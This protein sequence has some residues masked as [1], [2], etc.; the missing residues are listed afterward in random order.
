MAVEPIDSITRVT[1]MRRMYG[2]LEHAPTPEERVEQVQE[3]QRG[4]RPLVARQPA[5]VVPP[6]DRDL[7][8]TILDVERLRT[9]DDQPPGPSKAEVEA[10]YRAS[11]LGSQFWRVAELPAV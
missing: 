4:T 10:A 2:A 9:R 5:P 6:S 1:R 11:I 3:L 7:H 8:P